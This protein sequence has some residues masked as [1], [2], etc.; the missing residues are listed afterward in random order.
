MYIRSIFTTILFSVVLCGSVA[1]AKAPAADNN[2]T[3]SVVPAVQQTEK[4]E[5]VVINDIGTVQV[6]KVSLYGISRYEVVAMLNHLLE[7]VQVATHVEQVETVFAPARPMRCKAIW[8]V[9]ATGEDTFALE[10]ELFAI[11]RELKA[12]GENPVFDELLFTPEPDDIELLKQIRPSRATED[13]LMLLGP[14]LRKVPP[15]S[16][17]IVPG[18]RFDSGFD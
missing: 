12:E 10:S 13:S 5:Q 17:A 15:A 18:M 3:G 4:N 16:P 9:T 7:Q 14:G 8:R 1:H 11:I 6:V 2:V